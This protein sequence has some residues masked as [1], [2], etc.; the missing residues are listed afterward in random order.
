MKLIRLYWIGVRLV[1]GPNVD[2]GPLAHQLGSW[3]H[4]LL[5]LALHD[6]M[7]IM[8]YFSVSIS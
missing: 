5:Y 8:A 1:V 7:S 2:S 6:L 4:N 3:Q